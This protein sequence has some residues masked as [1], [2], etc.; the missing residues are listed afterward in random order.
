MSIPY[1]VSPYK[2]PENRTQ[3]MFRLLAKSYNRTSRQWL[4]EDMTQHTSL[5]YE[6]ASTA[7]DYLF[8]AIP[9]FLRLGMTVQLGRLGYFRY[10]IK[11]E[12]SEDPTDVTVDK[13]KS[14]HLRFFPGEG[15]REEVNAFPVSKWEAHF[16]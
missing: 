9:R 6:E 8:E 2:N 5:T 15:I 13:I 4:I 1:I 3:T 7:I 16:E 12:G 14:I 10:T 11:S